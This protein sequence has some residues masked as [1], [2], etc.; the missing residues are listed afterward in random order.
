MILVMT[1]YIKERSI[2]NKMLNLCLDYGFERIQANSYLG[3]LEER[4]RKQFL[5]E[6]R[7]FKSEHICTVRVFAAKEK[8]VGG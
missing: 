5:S 7:R 8:G 1:P 2:R 4:L 3:D 6:V